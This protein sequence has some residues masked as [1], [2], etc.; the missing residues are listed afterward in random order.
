M[1][2]TAPEGNKTS[3]DCPDMAKNHN[4][5]KIGSLCIFLHQLEHFPKTAS[6]FSQDALTALS[7][8]SMRMARKSLILVPVEP[9]M[10]KSPSFSKT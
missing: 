7:T 1:P 3:S 8:Y 2:I 4:A 5:G 10:N 6:H 9:V